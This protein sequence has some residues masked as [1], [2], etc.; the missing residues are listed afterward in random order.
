MKFSALIATTFAIAA[1]ALPSTAVSHER[2][3]VSLWPT[4]S[5]PG[6]YADIQPPDYSESQILQWLISGDVTGNASLVAQFPQGFAVTQSGPAK[7]DVY[8]RTTAGSTY[9]GTIGPLPVADGVITE[10]VF[11]VIATFPA[12]SDF[13]FE[14]ELDSETENASILFFEDD[15]SGFFIQTGA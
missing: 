5:D 3:T 2:R 10:D 8:R 12:D 1:S 14:F 4:V 15:V 9:V 7:L 6:F 13:V 11:T